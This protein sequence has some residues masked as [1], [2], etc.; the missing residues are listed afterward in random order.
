[1]CNVFVLFGKGL[2]KSGVKKHRRLSGFV[3]FVLFCKGLGKGV[4][5]RHRRLSSSVT[6]VIKFLKGIAFTLVA[7]CNAVSISRLSDFVA[8]VIISFG[9]VTF[10]F[11]IPV[12][13]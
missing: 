4:A 11:E 12:S 2:G 9:F 10:F 8:F 6:F 7:A 1:M 3:A 13:L 5:K